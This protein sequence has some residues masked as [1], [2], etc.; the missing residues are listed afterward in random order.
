MKKCIFAGKWEFQ[1]TNKEKL[2]I[3]KACTSSK[4][5]IATAMIAVTWKGI[6]PNLPK[7]EYKILPIM[8]IVSGSAKR[9][10]LRLPYANYTHK[11]VLYTEK[12]TLL[13]V[14]NCCFLYKNISC[15]KRMCMFVRRKGEIKKKTYHNFSQKAGCAS[16]FFCCLKNQSNP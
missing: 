16:C 8:G 5:L 3:R 7:R 13:L 6:L 2:W 12:I 10:A 15:P 14:K 11:N 1:H 9:L 4:K